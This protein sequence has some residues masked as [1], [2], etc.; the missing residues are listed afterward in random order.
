[1]KTLNLE[2]TTDILI[3]FA[4]STEEMMYVRGGEVNEGNVLPVPGPIKI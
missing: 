4:L 2:L 3:E 1:M